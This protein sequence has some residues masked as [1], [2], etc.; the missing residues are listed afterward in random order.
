MAMPISIDIDKCTSRHLTL[1]VLQ[2][3]F[4]SDDNHAAYCLILQP[5]DP[6]RK[7]GER[8]NREHRLCAIERLHI[9]QLNTA[10]LS[11][12]GECVAV[13]CLQTKRYGKSR[14]QRS[15]AFTDDN[16]LTN[17][18]HRDCSHLAPIR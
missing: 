10:T 6:G 18:L 11:L 12:G 5:V 14:K 1:R 8:A 7:F 4:D 9:C 3:G 17:K 16:N 2:M 15:S 13:F